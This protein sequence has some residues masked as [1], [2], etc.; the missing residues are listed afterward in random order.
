MFT[1]TLVLLTPPCRA[2]GDLYLIALMGQSNMVGEGRLFDLPP[3]FP[4]NSTKLWNFT[5]AYK[6]ELAKEPIDS[7]QA[8]VDV[9]S[10]DKRAGVGPALAM[11]DAFVSSH[12]SISVGLIPCAKGGSSVSE[13]Q[14]I[15][16]ANPRTTLF[17]SCLNRMKAASPNGALRA[18]IFWQGARDGKTQDAASRWGQRFTAFSVPSKFTLEVFEQVFLCH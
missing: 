9:V 1:F 6:W 15:P 5:N 3:R 10:L 7:P 14:K 2:Q 4:R 12:P 16:A 8:Q 18:A 17:G 13:W 11:A